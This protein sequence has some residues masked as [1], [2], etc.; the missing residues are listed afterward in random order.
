MVRKMLHDPLKAAGFSMWIDED[1]LQGGVQWPDQIAAAI[2]YADAMLVCLSKKWSAKGYVHTEIGLALDQI[3]AQPGDALLVIPVL[4]EECA[5]PPQLSAHHAIHLYKD[6]GYKKLVKDL[7]KFRSYRNPASTLEAL[8]RRIKKHPSAK[9]YV[10]R[11][12]AYGTLLNDPKRAIEDFDAAI[13]LDPAFTTAYMG[14]GHAYSAL[15]EVSTG[16]LSRFYFYHSA[17]QAFN[18]AVQLKK[19]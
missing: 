12:L 3:K 7:R 16:S 10:E 2:R 11:G 14:R 9:A 1:A 4:L 8:D 18:Q 17:I 5:I 13:R 15:A 6:G 19:Q